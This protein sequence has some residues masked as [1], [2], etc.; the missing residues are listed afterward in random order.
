MTATA[1]EAEQVLA[2]MTS[3]LP[4]PEEP[5]RKDKKWRTHPRKGALTRRGPPR[6]YRR[7][8]EETLHVRIQKLTTRLE[9][10]KSQV[11]LSLQRRAFRRWQRLT[12]HAVTT[13]STTRHARC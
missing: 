9:R 4:A 13:G 1:P 2:A 11:L 12:P 6:P 8:A 3:V 10:A 7:L 5:K